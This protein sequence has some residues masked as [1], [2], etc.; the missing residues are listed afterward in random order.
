M[1]A[2]R[3]IAVQTIALAG[4]LSAVALVLLYLASVV[5]S[6]W[7]GVTAVAGLTVA[8][9]VSAAGLRTG[10]MAYIVSSLL[11]LLLLPAKQV[12]LLYLCLFGLYPL[13]KLKLERIKAKAAE[14][15]L[16][17]VYFNVVLVVLYHA[18][19][20]LFF[21]GVEWTYAVPLL[22]VLMVAG[23]VIF[24]VYDFAFSK[25]MAMLQARLIPQLRRRF[26]RG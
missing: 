13:L 17:L 3:K 11:A 24:L 19:F 12:A 22:P 23:S 10:L 5:P 25:V 7:A 6:G 9:A 26:G 18:A 2:P 4:L 16:K 20:A 15:L 1:A 8:V 21:S 14:Y